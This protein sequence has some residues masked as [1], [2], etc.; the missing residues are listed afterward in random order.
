MV[1]YRYD[2]VA[3]QAV[4]MEINGRFWGSFPLSVH[5]GAGFALYA[6]FTQGLG[7]D[8]E[9]PAPR[10]DLRLRM[11]LVEIKR[12]FRILFQAHKI[13]DKTFARKP[14][15]EIA[16]FVLDFL[17]PKS[18]YCLFS[19]DDPGPFVADAQNILSTLFHWLAQRRFL[20]HG[21]E[22]IAN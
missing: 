3:D 11:V 9:A 10:E 14:F 17:N 1:E 13:Q 7:K 4:L 15:A 21:K 12:L 20:R 16:R 5:C 18:R 6:Y 19:L 8:M 22:R 2:P